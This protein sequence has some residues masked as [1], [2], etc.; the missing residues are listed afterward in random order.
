LV[1]CVLTIDAGTSDE[2]R[3]LI[4][5]VEAYLGEKD[6]ASHA[7]RGPTPRAAIMFGPPGHLYVYFT[8][9]MHRRRG[10]CGPAAGGGGGER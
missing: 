8:Y 9:G 2:V 4:V 7:H 3:A 10:G 6:P 1:G 5:E